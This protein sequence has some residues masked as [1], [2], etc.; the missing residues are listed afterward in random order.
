MFLSQRT[1]E[2]HWTRFVRGLRKG[3]DHSSHSRF[4]GSC[5]KVVAADDRNSSVRGGGVELCHSVDIKES[6]LTA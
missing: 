5:G 1:V 6:G 4:R 2:K 3:L